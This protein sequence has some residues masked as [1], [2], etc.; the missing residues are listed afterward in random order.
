MPVNRTRYR[1][2]YPL[3]EFECF[4]HLKRDKLPNNM[5]LLPSTNRGEMVAI[6]LT[7]QQAKERNGALFPKDPL[8]GANC[9]WDLDWTDTFDLL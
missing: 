3:W 2:L 7:E 9:E 6:Y 4:Y 1:L 5:E 8:T